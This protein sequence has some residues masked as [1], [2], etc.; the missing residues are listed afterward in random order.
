MLESRGQAGLLTAPY[1]AD[2][3]FGRNTLEEHG[4]PV[5]DRKAEMRTIDAEEPVFLHD[6]YEKLKNNT[7]NVLLGFSTHVAI[8]QMHLHKPAD[9]ESAVRSYVS[10]AFSLLMSG[11][12]KMI[13]ECDLTT[14]KYHHTILSKAWSYFA[15]GLSK[16]E[17]VGAIG[18]CKHCHRFFEQQRNTKQFCSDSCGVM[19]LQSYGDEQAEDEPYETDVMRW[20]A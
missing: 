13:N 19:H 7:G 1:H 3:F 5:G 16:E 9:M 17:R 6:Y 15:D 4:L 11:E 10:T 20:R 14:Y 2:C 8:K 12:R 18:V